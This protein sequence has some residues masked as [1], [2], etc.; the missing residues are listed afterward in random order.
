[1]TAA[2]ADEVAPV[3]YRPMLEH[4]RR[5]IAGMWLHNTQG[6]WFGPTLHRDDYWRG[7]ERLVH[8]LLDRCAVLVAAFVED[9]ETIIGWACTSTGAVHYVW[10]RNGFRRVGIASKLLAPYLDKPT[11]YTHPPKSG[12][13]KPPKAW[14]YNP[15]AAFELAYR[16]GT[17]EV[18]T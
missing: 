18:N 3:I 1:M 5:S 10:V 17:S 2:L 9:P 15:F 13:V 7:Q 6:T 12:W 16:N 11:T 8:A 4:E 14:V